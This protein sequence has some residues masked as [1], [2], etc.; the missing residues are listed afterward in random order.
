MSKKQDKIY[1]YGS[2]EVGSLIGNESL[3]FSDTFRY[4]FKK[5]ATQAFMFDTI[6]IY[7]FMP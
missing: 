4:I 2:R 6:N 7:I 1:Y 3:Q 5:I